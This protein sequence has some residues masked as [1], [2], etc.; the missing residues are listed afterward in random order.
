MLIQI[1][2]SGGIETSGYSSQQGQHYDANLP[3]AT[4][5]GLTVMLSA[6]FRST[7]GMSEWYCQDS[8]TNHWHGR[9]SSWTVDWLSSGVTAKTLSGTL[10]RISISS[11]AS[12]TFDAGT[13]N[14]IYM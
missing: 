8:S 12:D 14:I 5:N 4:T 6:A 1:G 2:D 7:I 13:A 3:T 10:D 11:T 9:Y